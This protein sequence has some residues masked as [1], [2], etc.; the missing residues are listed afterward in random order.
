MNH[1]SSSNSSC[2]KFGLD[3]LKKI[4][5]DLHDGVEINKAIAAHTEPAAGVGKEIR[6]FRARTGGESRAGSGPDKPPETRSETERDVWKAAHPNNYYMRMEK[7]TELMKA[8]KWAEAKP[9][10]ESLAETYHGES[11]AENPMWLLAVTQRNLRE[12]NA[13]LATLQKFAAQESDFVDLYCRLIELCRRKQ[14]LGRRDKIR[15]AVA[16]H[17]SADPVAAPRLAEAGVA[18][19]NGEQAIT[20]Y[21]KL[22]WLD[23]PDPGGSAFSIGATAA[24]ARRCRMPRPS[25]RFCRRWRKRPGSATPSGCF[26]KSKK[27]RRNPTKPAASNAMS[28]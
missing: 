5:G 27:N 23:P 15:R 26:W 7:A 28:P 1:R 18:P 11:R 22:L 19:G 20:A 4:L 12:T 17:Q 9:V 10:L 16:G 8:K 3:S 2:E 6:R 14:G 13:E 21:R 25:A 24:R